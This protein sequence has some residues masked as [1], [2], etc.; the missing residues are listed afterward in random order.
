MDT[1]VEPG[2]DEYGMILAYGLVLFRQ[3]ERDRHQ[4]QPRASLRTTVLA[5]RLPSPAYSSW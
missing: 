2:H 3:K 4:A 5:L 1:R